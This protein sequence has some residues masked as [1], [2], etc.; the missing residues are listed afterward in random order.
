MK[1][2]I[3][4]CFGGF[5]LSEVALKQYE[6]LS[7]KT[8]VYPNDIER[9]DRHLVQVVEELKGHASDALSEL[10]I[11]EIPNCVQWEITEYDGKEW[12]NEKHRTWSYDT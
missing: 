2:V 5:G 10:K 12:V 7:G 6:K 11:I 3:N 8:D 4:T 1:V 9:D